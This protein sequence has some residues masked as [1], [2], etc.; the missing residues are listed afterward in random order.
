V[1]IGL[2]ATEPM[3]RLG[4]LLM[5]SETEL[6]LKSRWVVPTRLLESGFTFT[7]PTWPVAARDLVHRALAG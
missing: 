1:K 7:F 2:P 6:V 3:L 5:H 4:A